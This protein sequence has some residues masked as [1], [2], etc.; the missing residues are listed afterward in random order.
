[1]RTNE[2]HR[3][4]RGAN[5]FRPRLEGLEDRCCPS[6]N[7][8]FNDGTLRLS[9]NGAADEITIRATGEDRIRVTGFTTG[10]ATRDFNRVDRIVINLG[11]GANTINLNLSA[12][13]DVDLHITG[14]SGADTVN[15]NTNSV[16]GDSDLN[17]TAR[18]G[19]GDDQFTYTSNGFTGDDAHLDLNI[20]G[21]AGNDTV[22]F[23]LGAVREG[24]EVDIHANLGN[25]LNRLSGTASRFEEDSSLELEIDGGNDRDVVGLSLGEL[26][27]DSEVFADINLRGGNDN[28]KSSLF[29]LDGASLEMFVDAGAGDDSVT[30]GFGG[31]GEDSEVDVD[32][33]LGDGNDQFSMPITRAFDDDAEVE[34]HVD[35]GNGNDSANITARNGFGDDFDLQL[36]NI[37]TTSRPR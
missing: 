1:M 13:A 14:G 11:G 29:V 24:S 2:H 26:F 28:L 10:A 3:K 36:D 37:G 22:R 21:G 27:E 19:N 33:R 20:E 8:S 18:L 17:V 9:G 16:N 32:V 34:V 30:L 25:G 12:D 7:S 6:V 4:N 35:G 15:L 31:F 5:G 23:A